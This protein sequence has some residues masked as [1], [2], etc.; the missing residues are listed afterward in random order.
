MR[1]SG[2]KPPSVCVWLFGSEGSAQSQIGF[3]FIILDGRE[4]PAPCRVFGTL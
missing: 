2:A 1:E 4:R 3:G